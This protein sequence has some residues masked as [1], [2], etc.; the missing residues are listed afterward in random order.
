MKKNDS[1]RPTD[2]D[3]RHPGVSEERQRQHAVGVGIG[4]LVVRLLPTI[5][6]HTRSG[7]PGRFILAWMINLFFDALV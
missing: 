1:E 2:E 5:Q 6:V 4:P 7:E 3:L